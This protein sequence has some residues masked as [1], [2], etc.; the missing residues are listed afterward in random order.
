VKF[1]REEITSKTNKYLTWEDDIKTD[2][3][4]M[5]WDSSGLEKSPLAGYC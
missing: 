2:I 1:W 5:W 4:E 3:K